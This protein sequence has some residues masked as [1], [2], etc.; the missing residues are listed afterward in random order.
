MSGYTVD[1]SV[2]NSRIDKWIINGCNTVEGKIMDTA[3]GFLIVKKDEVQKKIG[4]PRYQFPL[5]SPLYKVFTLRLSDIPSNFLSL[6]T[7]KTIM[8]EMSQDYVYARIAKKKRHIYTPDEVKGL[9]AI[10][11]NT[12]V[13][14]TNTPQY[15]DSIHT[16][17]RM[18]GDLPLRINI[19]ADLRGTRYTTN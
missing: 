14:N 4:N 8:S 2:V 17:M 18:Y 5:S 12:I 6:A 9:R 13:P 15:Y 7:T 11:A 3:E 16:C 10:C 1:V 19:Y